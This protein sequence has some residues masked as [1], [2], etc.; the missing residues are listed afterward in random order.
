MKKLKVFAGCTEF[1]SEV[2]AFKNRG[3]DAITLGLEGDVN[4]K[5]D[6]CDFHTNEQ[7]D[8]MWF[9]PPCTDFSIAKGVACKDRSVDLSIVE[10]CFRIVKEAKPD[11]W[12]IENPRGCLRYFIGKPT[13]TINYSDYGFKTIKPTDL[14]GVFPWFYSTTARIKNIISFQNIPGFTKGQKAE[15]SRVPY[16]LSLAIC[17]AMENTI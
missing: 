10:A 13:I 3:H 9:S 14:W 15:R 7:Y 11:F 1:G 6:I 4:I 16:G 2:Q 5:M 8:L 12:I 17:K